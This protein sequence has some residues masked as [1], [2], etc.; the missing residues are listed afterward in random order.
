MSDRV[1]A[2]DDEDPAMDKTPAPNVGTASS[3]LRRPWEMIDEDVD[4]M[5][6]MGPMEG[7][8]GQLGDTM[9]P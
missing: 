6:T 1:V 9:K 5:S 3:C 4:E 2:S 7:G 8:P